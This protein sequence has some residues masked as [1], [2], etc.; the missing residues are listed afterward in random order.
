MVVQRLNWKPTRST[1]ILRNAFVLEATSPMHA[2]YSNHSDTIADQASKSEGEDIFANAT[3]KPPPTADYRSWYET[4]KAKLSTGTN[5]PHFLGGNYP[6]SLNPAY[7]PKPPLANSMRKHIYETWR[8]DPERWTPLQLSLKHSISVDRVRAI[9]KLGSLKERVLQAGW[10]VN[11]IYARH[12]ESIL[13]ARSES[14][15]PNLS[16]PNLNECDSTEELAGRM[17]PTLYAVPECHDLQPQQAARILGRKLRPICSKVEAS[18]NSELPYDP[19]PK[20]HAVTNNTSLFIRNDHYEKSRWR[21]IFMDIPGGSSSGR[22]PRQVLIREK[23]GD[24]R[25]ARHNEIEE[26]HGARA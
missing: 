10:L 23:N 4:I 15:E 9:I 5:W 8:S 21:F 14:F 20:K 2:Q 16:R 24:L 1:I 19:R 13:G 11:R 26:L 18:L 17:P 6:F 12:M 22:K 7:K 25:N 3:S